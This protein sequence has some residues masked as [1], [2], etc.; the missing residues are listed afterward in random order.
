MQAGRNSSAINTSR[1]RKFYSD[2][3]G[4]TNS[5]RTFLMLCD[6]NKYGRQVNSLTVKTSV[7]VRVLCQPGRRALPRPG[8]RPRTVSVRMQLKLRVAEGVPGQNP[9]GR[10]I[11]QPLVYRGSKFP[12]GSMWNAWDSAHAPRR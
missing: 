4:N 5:V 7:G 6:R 9:V 10:R 1:T 12:P 2:W 8:S 3:D 11:Q